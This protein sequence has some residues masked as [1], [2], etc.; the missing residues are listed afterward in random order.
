MALTPEV[1]VNRES[2]V[3]SSSDLE[4]PHRSRASLLLKLSAGV[5]TGIVTV[6]RPEVGLT[7]MVVSGIGGWGGILTPVAFPGSGMGLERYKDK[8]V[9]DQLKFLV[10][11]AA[12]GVKVGALAGVAIAAKSLLWG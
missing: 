10:R 6:M 7:I 5:T 8:T 4:T 9:S 11:S 12:T 2:P 3:V 1:S